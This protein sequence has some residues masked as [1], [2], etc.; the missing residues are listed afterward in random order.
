MFLGLSTL[1]I[2]AIHLIWPTLLWR[3]ARRQTPAPRW[4]APLMRLIAVYLVVDGL[5]ILGVPIDSW[6]PF[7]API[8]THP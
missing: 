2:G 7:L 8:L 6:L 1:V 5:S 4:V 3:W